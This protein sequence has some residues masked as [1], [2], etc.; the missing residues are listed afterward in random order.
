MLFKRQWKQNPATGLDSSAP[1]LYYDW[2]L[3]QSGRG[4]GAGFV[5]MFE[6]LAET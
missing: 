6:A 1:V 3:T 2:L 4:E 5:G